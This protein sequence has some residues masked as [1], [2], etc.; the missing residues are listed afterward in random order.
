MSAVMVA[1]SLAALLPR[2]LPGIA[3]CSGM[4]YIKVEDKMKLKELWME[5]VRRGNVIRVYHKELLSVQ[6][7][8]VICVDECPR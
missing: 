6:K 5:N 3:E 8:T 2:S 7:I 1:D 4:H